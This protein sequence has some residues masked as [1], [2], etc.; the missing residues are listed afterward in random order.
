MAKHR[1][2]QRS[3]IFL[4]GLNV[5]ILISCNSAT[6]Q[7]KSSD[8]TNNATNSVT[9][10]QPSPAFNLDGK[11]DTLYATKAKFVALPKL[12][13]V[14]SFSF[15]RGSISDELTMHGWSLKSGGPHNFPQG[16]PDL[17][18]ARGNPDINLNYGPG[19]YFGNVVLEK[20][21]VMDIQTE[22]ESGKGFEYVGFSPKKDTLTHIKYAIFLSKKEPIQKLVPGDIMQLANTYANPSPP[23]NQ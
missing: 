1:L 14:F 9:K 4:L 3:A 20:Q 7:N 23:R 19:S 21:A 6:D 12:K 15:E 2:I 22:L 13:L 16:I 8:S 11:Y 18:L 10:N 17:S 5:L